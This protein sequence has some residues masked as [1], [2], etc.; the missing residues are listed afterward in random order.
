MINPSDHPDEQRRKALPW[1]LRFLLALGGRLSPVQPDERRLILRSARRNG[2]EG[3]I[4]LL[5]LCGWTFFI[6]AMA[7]QSPPKAVYDI[8]IF[9]LMGAIGVGV[10]CFVLYS[11]TARDELCVEVDRLT[12]TLRALLPLR[13]R[14]VALSQVRNVQLVE[15]RD[16]GSVSGHAIRVISA[17]PDIIFGRSESDTTLAPIARQ[18]RERIEHLT[19]RALEPAPRLQQVEQETRERHARVKAAA[20]E[21]VGAKSETELESDPERK[22]AAVKYMIEQSVNHAMHRETA[23][24]NVPAL[25]GPPGPLNNAFRAVVS[26]CAALV[27]MLFAVIWIGATIGLIARTIAHRNWMMIVVLVPF[28][29]ISLLMALVLWG[30]LSTAAQGIAKG[31]RKLFGRDQRD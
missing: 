10:G 21:S 13:R 8:S 17:D 7:R 18:L 20:L 23:E 12:Y 1:R 4:A 29:G 19:G 11:L 14:S 22:R 31:I 9:T 5:W 16:R 15:M 27:W 2:C 30:G 28:V 6:I 26:W 25:P 24:P 3:V